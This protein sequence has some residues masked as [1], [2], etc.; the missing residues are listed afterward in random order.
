MKKFL[1]G[2]EKIFNNEDLTTLA[3]IEMYSKNML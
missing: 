3:L 2:I 1:V